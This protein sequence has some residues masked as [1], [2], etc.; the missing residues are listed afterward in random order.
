MPVLLQSKKS[1]WVNS[2]W[3]YQGSLSSAG[4]QMTPSIPTQPLISM[5][6]KQMASRSGEKIKIKQYHQ[7]IFLFMFHS[8][9]DD[10][11]VWAKG[12]QDYWTGNICLPHL[13]LWPQVSQDAEISY[14]WCSA[15]AGRA[16]E[17]EGQTQCSVSTNY[18]VTFYFSGVQGH[19]EESLSFRGKKV[20]WWRSR[21]EAEEWW[22]GTPSW[23]W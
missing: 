3:R 21:W 2:L 18:P 13:W 8:C 10:L 6:S 20:F 19:T 15:P 14:C 23:P 1:W 7:E 9:C 22:A 5:T 17:E 16:A 4:L 12:S 11:Q